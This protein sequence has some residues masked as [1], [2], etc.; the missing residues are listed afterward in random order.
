MDSTDLFDV[1]EETPVEL[2][3]K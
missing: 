3:T 1:F 2:P